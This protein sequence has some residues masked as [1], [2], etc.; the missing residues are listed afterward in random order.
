LLWLLTGG[1]SDSLVEPEMTD[2]EAIREK[3]NQAITTGEEFSKRYYKILDQ[4]RHAI[5][6]MYH[7][8]A[9]L[10]WNGNAVEGVT[11]IKTFLTEKLPKTNTYLNSL[12]AQPVH[13]S[14]VQG[15][16]T[17]LVIVS[18]VHL[19]HPFT[20]CGQVSGTMKLGSSAPKLFQENF[21][22]TAKDSKWKIV[23]DTFRSQ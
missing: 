2:D 5:D 17:L 12:D 15:Q 13:D 4:E 9:V 8:E 20:A 19:V 22:L 14:A 11:S 6:K 10:A 18:I 7:E 23:A 1:L 3:I 21:M 16:T